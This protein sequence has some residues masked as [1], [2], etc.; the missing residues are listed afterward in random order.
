MKEPGPGKEREKVS[1]LSRHRFKCLIFTYYFNLNS[2]QALIS[3][4][5]NAARDGL[6][7]FS[8]R[9]FAEFLQTVVDVDC[10][11]CAGT[12]PCE[13]LVRLVIE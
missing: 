2:R 9:E 1:V 10:Q 4:G 13:E 6:F 12:H 11:S 8:L 7:S 3:V 5:F